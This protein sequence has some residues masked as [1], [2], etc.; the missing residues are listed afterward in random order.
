MLVQ[1]LT[2]RETARALGVSTAA[3]SLS[4]HRIGRL[5]KREISKL[6]TKLF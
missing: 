6:E 1:G 3:V 2:S 4:K 5:L